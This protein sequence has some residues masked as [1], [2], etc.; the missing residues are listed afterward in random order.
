LKPS[1]ID[2]AQS[3]HREY[4]KLVHRRSLLSDDSDVDGLNSVTM[5]F[6]RGRDGTATVNLYGADA[7]AVLQMARRELDARIQATHEDLVAMGVEADLPTSVSLQPDTALSLMPQRHAP[8]PMPMDRSDR[9]T[10][11]GV[12]RLA[13][14]LI[15]GCM[16]LAQWLK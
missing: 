14:V 3:L 13:L 5:S 9:W 10:A 12:T 8:K 1:D 11:G 15:V 4:E 6:D 16:L 2:H 7:L